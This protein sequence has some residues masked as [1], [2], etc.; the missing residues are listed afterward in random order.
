MPTNYVPGFQASLELF[1]DE[2]DLGSISQEV[3]PVSEVRLIGRVEMGDDT[4]AGSREL[5]GDLHYT[6]TIGKRLGAWQA[7]REREVGR[8]NVQDPKP[9]ER[10][11]YVPPFEVSV[12]PFQLRIGRNAYQDDLCVGP[13]AKNTA[14]LNV[15]E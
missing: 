9:G 12:E 3:G 1:D 8:G 2:F 13:E 10:S 14:K 4:Q 7:K 6:R 5:L 11:R 15:V